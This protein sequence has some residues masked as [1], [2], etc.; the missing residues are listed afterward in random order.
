MSD[1][2]LVN[3][4]LYEA[5]LKYVHMGVLMGQTSLASMQSHFVRRDVAWSRR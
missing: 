2:V 4:A 5:G 1:E 3:P